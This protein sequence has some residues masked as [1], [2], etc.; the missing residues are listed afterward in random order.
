MKRTLLKQYHI[1]NQD[2]KTSLELIDGDLELARL[3]SLVN[4]KLL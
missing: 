3:S 4:N 2:L 1:L